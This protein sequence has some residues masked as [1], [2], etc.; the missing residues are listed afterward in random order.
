[1]RAIRY[2]TAETDGLKQEWQGRGWLNPPYHRALAPAFVEKLVA[3]FR[4]GRTTAAIMLTNNGTDTEWFR[5]AHAAC[6]AIC[7]TTGRINFVKPGGAEVF[8]TQGQTF[9]YFGDDP[10]RFAEVFRAIGLLMR[11]FEEG[12]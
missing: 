5:C 8:P 1:V 9:F 10:D 12:A 4:A 6:A 11:P 3:E 7:F 2:F